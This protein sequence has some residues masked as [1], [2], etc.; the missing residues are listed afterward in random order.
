VP[1]S[2]APF[3][4]VDFAG[5]VYSAGNDTILGSNF[6]DTLGGSSGNDSINGYDG[7]DWLVVGIG[8]NTFDGGKGTGDVID[9]SGT[10]KPVVLHLHGSTAAPI[11]IGGNAAGTAVNIETIIGGSKD[12]KLTGDGNAN[13]LLGLAG[14]DS[15]DG[16]GGVD[17]ANYSNT[18]KAV[19]VTLN[20]SSWV[21]VKIAGVAEDKLSNI[22]D[23]IGGSKSDAL[24]GD[25][26]NNYLAGQAGNDTLSGGTGNDVLAGATGKD[27][28]R[29]GSGSDEFIFREHVGSA[30]A[31]VIMDYSHG[32]DVIALDSGI[33]HGLG[34]PG[35]R[36]GPTHF[37][38]ASGPQHAG[39]AALIYSPTSGRLYYDDD[40][41]GGHDIELVLTFSHKP[42][43]LDSNDFY[44]L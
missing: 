37:F 36:V 3:T 31:D 34:T 13:V 7:N 2:N 42:S 4:G 28:L 26:K 19:A 21:D 9:F 25:S 27:Q 43:Y 14:K 11:T 35:H 29:G 15:L 18:T 10:I 20:G 38:V 8:I 39:Q 44:L 16:G 40:G 24:T 22:E 5:D 6:D 32:H 1:S 23:L 33:F 12:D 17:T 30:N 41:K